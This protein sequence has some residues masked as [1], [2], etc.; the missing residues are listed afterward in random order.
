VVDV[1]PSW[2]SVISS[3]WVYLSAIGG[4][5]ERRVEMKGEKERKKGT[6]QGYG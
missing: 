6:S 3:R 1:I 5:E 4:T 2:G